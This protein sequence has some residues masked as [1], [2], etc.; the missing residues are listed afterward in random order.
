MA[1][2][3]REAVDYTEA[4]FLM[5]QLGTACFIVIAYLTGMRPG[6]AAGLRSGCCPDPEPESAERTG[7]HLITS[8]VYK[9]ARDEDGNHR[10][11]GEVRDAPWVAIAP[12]VNAIRVLERMVPQGQ[13]LFDH[14]AHDLRGTRAG[15][16]SLAVH[17][18]GTRVK[19]FITWA[20]HE[21]TARGLA[22]EVIP[23]DPHGRI[24]TERFRRS[25][26]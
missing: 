7:R 2:P 4:G 12:V 16:L 15:T 14:H 13:L 24:G 18:L 3:W 1:P 6:E 10:S 22:H 8:T 20:N 17:T 19:D 21:A 5:R 26:A 25:L 23:P 9:T 11:E